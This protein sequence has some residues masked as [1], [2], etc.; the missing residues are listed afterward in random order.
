LAFFRLWGFCGYRDFSATAARVPQSA[1]VCGLT[2]ALQT[3]A[4]SPTVA[5]LAQRLTIPLSQSP[6]PLSQW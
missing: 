1:D 5:V 4:I 2:L 3:I 6:K